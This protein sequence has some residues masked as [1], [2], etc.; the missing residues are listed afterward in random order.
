MAKI[1]VRFVQGGV[2]SYPPRGCNEARPGSAHRE[3]RQEERPRLYVVPGEASGWI[4]GE[5]CALKER[6]CGGTAAQ[7]V[8]GES[9]SL[10][11]SQSR[12]DVALRAVVS[13]RG[14]AGMDAVRRGWTWRCESSFPTF[15]TR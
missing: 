15:I 14:E 3:Q 13:G 10:E 8:G 9:P 5:K 6:C 7:G 2:S 4:L 11:V 12:G 1:N